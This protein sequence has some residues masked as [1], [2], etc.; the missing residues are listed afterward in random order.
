MSADPI[1]HAIA[2]AEKP[3][4]IRMMRIPV[5]IASTKR[6]AV[7]ELPADISDAEL[8]ELIGWLAAVVA[9]QLRAQRESPRSRILVPS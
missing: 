1:D 8:L 6:P 2:A 3:V 4:Q 5:T 7:V 9:P